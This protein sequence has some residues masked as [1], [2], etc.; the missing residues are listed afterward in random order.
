MTS[1]NNQ[2]MC[3]ITRIRKHKSELVKIT[4]VQNIWYIDKNYEMFGRSIY[5]DLNPEVLKKFSK[6]IRRFKI[7]KENFEQILKQLEEMI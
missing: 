7:D 6:Q 2:R 1:S 5:L 3:V 4:K